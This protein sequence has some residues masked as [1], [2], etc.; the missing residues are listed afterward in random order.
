MKKAS[1]G[2]FTLIELIIVIAIIGILSAIIVPN[3]I[4]YQAKARQV[5]A[6]VDLGGIFVAANTYYASHA[7]YVV[8]LSSDLGF[9]AA[10]S[11]VYSFNYGGIMISAGSTAAVCSG[12]T[13]VDTS[14]AM[15]WAGFTAGARGNIDSDPTCDEWTINDKRDLVNTVD[16]ILE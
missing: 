11:P 5:E 13:W 6:K 8:A 15:T 3:F 10:G 2:G 12:T 9:T 14:P 4:L 1:D 7:S 16:D